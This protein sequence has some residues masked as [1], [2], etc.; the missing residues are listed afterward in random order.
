MTFVNFTDEMSVSISVSTG[1][2][3]EAQ[4]V[5]KGLFLPF[6]SKSQQLCWKV[7]P[8][9]L[10]PGPQLF[11]LLEEELCAAVLV[12]HCLYL[13][14]C[15][16]LFSQHSVLTPISDVSSSAAQPD[17]L[18]HEESILSFISCPHSFLYAANYSDSIL[19]YKMSCQ[20]H[21]GVLRTL[22]EQG[23]SFV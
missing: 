10:C 15:F 14:I 7:N 16:T 3:A 18:L 22:P 6:H 11:L 23:C 19:I 1:G 2:E 8:V 9:L 12:M 20:S 21:R 17:I 13:Q 4:V 5:R